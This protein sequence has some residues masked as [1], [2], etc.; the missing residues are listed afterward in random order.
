MWSGINMYVCL[1]QGITDKDIR[2]AINDG[3]SSY[4]EVRQALDIAAQCGKCGCLA[5]Q[6]VKETITENQLSNP[7]VAYFNPAEMVSY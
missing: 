6:I 5:K 3:C 2:D 7:A 4:K 1:C